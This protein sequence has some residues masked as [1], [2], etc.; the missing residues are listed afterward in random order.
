MAAPA[1]D[2]PDYCG[3]EG[4]RLRDEANKYGDE[5]SKLFEASKK[6]FEENDKKKAKELSD[7]GKEAGR[8]M[9]E[10]H[11]KAAEVILHYRNDGKGEAYLD[12]HGLHLDEAMSA[13]SKKLSELQVAN[14]GTIFFEC[15]PGAGHHSSG[16][17]IIKPKV[18]E[19]LSKRKLPFEEK[20]AG[21]LMVTIESGTPDTNAVT[22]VDT[23]TDGVVGEEVVDLPL[24]VTSDDPP[25]RSSGFDDTNKKD[26]AE[27]P[28]SGAAGSCCI[29]M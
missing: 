25:V 19:E 7:Q 17:A 16:H 9:E 8:K 2:N 13:L 10:A 18:I 11:K 22:T 4:N 12:L 20:N 26:S 24:V 6:A 23:P 3:P 21:T 28:E 1:E 29:I 15:I 27:V 5:R 14:K